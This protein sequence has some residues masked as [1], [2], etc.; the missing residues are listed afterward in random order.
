MSVQWPVAFDK[1]INLVDIKLAS[2][3]KEYFC[4]D[5]GKAM[6]PHQGEVLQWHYAHKSEDESFCSGEG[7]EH[8]E[9]VNQIINTIRDGKASINAP[10]KCG[11]YEM[12]KIPTDS[13]IRCNK[14]VF[15]GSD[16]RPDIFIDG[17]IGHTKIAIEVVNYHYPDSAT[18]EYYSSNGIFV[19]IEYCGKEGGRVGESHIPK[20]VFCDHDKKRGRRPDKCFSHNRYEVAIWIDSKSTYMKLDP[21]TFYTEQDLDDAMVVLSDA[22]EFIIKNKNNIPFTNMLPMA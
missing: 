7:W 8:W 2:K 13:T 4:P 14:C 10:C 11:V 15:N 22:S 18:M 3:E 6:I 19:F 1:D 16:I 20:N 21:Q 12:F 5:C 9:R 17:M